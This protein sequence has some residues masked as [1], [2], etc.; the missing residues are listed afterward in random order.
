MAQNG[1]ISIM[2]LLLG[3]PSKQGHFFK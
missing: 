3:R 2:L 1:H